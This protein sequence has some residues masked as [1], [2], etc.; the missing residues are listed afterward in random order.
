MN[1]PWTDRLSGYLDGEL[2]AD[3][4]AELERHLT[5]CDECTA[6]LAALRTVV[7]AARSLPDRD[8]PPGQW[9]AIERRIDA[10]AVAPI[11]RG[12][13][14]FAFTLPQLAAASIALAAVSGGAVWLA[15]RPAP[16]VA[17]S[18]AGGE[19]AGAV[20]VSFDA[21]AYDRTIAELEAALEQTRDQLAPETVAAVERSLV[22]ID[23]AIADALEAL[24]NDPNDPFLVRHLERTM[25]RKMD[26]LKR[27]T[28]RAPAQT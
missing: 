8:P 23:A 27:A 10:D 15:T 17:P 2:E 9:Q 11:G 5:S 18:V 19:A 13:R 6:T 12:R 1:D 20:A 26:I 7:A 25:V 4:T 22:T 16:P 14:R 24:R 3:E 21:T 28:P